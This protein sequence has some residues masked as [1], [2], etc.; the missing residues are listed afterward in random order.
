MD[1]EEPRFDVWEDSVARAS[2][3]PLASDSEG[4]GSGI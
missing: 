1:V 2:I 3:R 4:E